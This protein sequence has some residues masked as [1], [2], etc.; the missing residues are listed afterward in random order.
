VADTDDDGADGADADCAGTR[1]VGVG[2][3]FYRRQMAMNDL[4]GGHNSPH[5]LLAWT[6]AFQ[7]HDGCCHARCSRR[8]ASY[9]L[10]VHAD[11]TCN[12]GLWTTSWFPWL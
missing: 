10:Y 5:A 8:E 12:S 7:T 3:S 6:E 1:G 2:S 9:P 11:C 4:A